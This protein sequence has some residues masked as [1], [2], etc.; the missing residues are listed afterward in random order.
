MKL[1]NLHASITTKII[2]NGVVN[3]HVISIRECNSKSKYIIYKGTE[4]ITADVCSAGAT[5][6]VNPNR[7]KM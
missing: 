6:G 4:P 2:H 3:Y 5:G 1:L 7:L